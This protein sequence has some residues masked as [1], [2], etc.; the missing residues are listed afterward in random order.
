MDIRKSYAKSDQY[1]AQRNAPS[2]ILVPF[3]PGPFSR[4]FSHGSGF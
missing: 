3:E 4:P 2:L 1:A